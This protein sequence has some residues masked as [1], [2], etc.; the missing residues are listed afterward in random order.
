MGHESVCYDSASA[1]EFLLKILES[2][3]DYLCVNLVYRLPSRID[4]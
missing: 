2:S 3:R 4:Q 1:R